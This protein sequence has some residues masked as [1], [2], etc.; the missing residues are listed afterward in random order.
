MGHMLKDQSRY[1]VYF[2]T[3]TE[4]PRCGCCNH[5]LHT[6]IGIKIQDTQTNETLHVGP[7]CLEKM[8]GIKPYNV[9]VISAGALSEKKSDTAEHINHQTTSRTDYSR[10]AHE[11][12]HKRR[13]DAIANAE[14]RGRALPQRRFNKAVMT[15]Q[16]F[17]KFSS[18][19]DDYQTE[20]S[21]REVE[22][23]TQRVTRREKRQQPD[24]KTLQHCMMTIVQL[25]HLLKHRDRLKPSDK[26][27][28]DQFRTR[29]RQNF[30]LSDPQMEQIERVTKNYKHLGVPNRINGIRFPKSE[31]NRQNR[32]AIAEQE[33]SQLKLDF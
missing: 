19:P 26:D 8:T 30:G 22:L 23:I 25:D 31:E 13:L 9:P 2:K 28:M 21:I 14:L 24:L 16:L 17:N 33:Q 1:R 32:V 4:D 20:E 18:D 10:A 11:P 12:L 6:G 7:V 15:P 29:L 3:A 27:M 5:P